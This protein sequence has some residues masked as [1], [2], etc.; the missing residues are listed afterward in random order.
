MI[1]R[2][3]RLEVNIL[4]VCVALLVGTPALCRAFAGAVTGTLAQA[5]ISLIRMRGA[6]TMR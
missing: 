2:M 1:G 4:C 5:V 3:A 6:P